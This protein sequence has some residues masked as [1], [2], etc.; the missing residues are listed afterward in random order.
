LAQDVLED[1]DE[2]SSGA[3][4]MSNK[5]SKKALSDAVEELDAARDAAQLKVHL[6]SMD[7][8]RT[9]DQLEDS[10]SSLKENLAREGEKVAEASAVAAR[11]L[12]RSIRR[13]VESHL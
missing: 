8:R 6:L 11:D 12:A 13:F 4:R 7:A 9:W 1:P 10:F 3:S 2:P 5:E